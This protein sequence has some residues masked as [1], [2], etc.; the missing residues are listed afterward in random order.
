MHAVKSHIVLTSLSN[1]L[2]FF[3]MRILKR[4]YK[5]E[6]FPGLIEFIESSEYFKTEYYQ[7]IK[8]E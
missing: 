5:N 3:T 7:N 8:S 6:K 1:F 2:L 4:I